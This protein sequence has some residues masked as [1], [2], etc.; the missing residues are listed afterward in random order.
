MARRE[1]VGAQGRGGGVGRRWENYTGR[2]W[3]VCGEVSHEMFKY[4]PNFAVPQHSG[5]HYL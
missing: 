5:S 3:R 1:V 4:Y 2:E